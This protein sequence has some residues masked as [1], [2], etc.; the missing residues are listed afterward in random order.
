[1]SRRAPEQTPSPWTPRSWKWTLV[2][3]LGWLLVATLLA[4]RA[5]RGMSW[6]FE[7]FRLGALAASAREPLYEAAAAGPGGYLY[8]P[9]FALALQ[10]LTWFSSDTGLAIWTGASLIALFASAQLLEGAV[11]RWLGRPALPMFGLVALLVLAVPTASN[12]RW[13]NSNAFMM[14]LITGALAAHVARRPQWTGLLLSL[15]ATIKLT[16]FLFLGWLALRRDGRAL[17]AFGAGSVLW[18]A[19]IPAAALGP[20]YAMSETKA[21]LSAVVFPAAAGATLGDADSSLPR[22]LERLHASRASKRAETQ[23]AGLADGATSGTPASAEGQTLG[24]GSAELIR[25]L[26]ILLAALL[27]ALTAVAAAREPGLGVLSFGATAAAML[28]AAPAARSGH[29]MQ[30]YPLVGILLACAMTAGQPRAPLARGGLLAAIASMLVLFGCARLLGV[31]SKEF[32]PVTSL[33][34]VLWGTACLLAL[35]DPRP[36]SERLRGP[37][38]ANHAQTRQP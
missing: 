20:S 37:G 25:G 29:F 36:S 3:A 19:V 31:S 16:P 2:G 7:L 6:D 5:F 9:I 18:L 4:V 30:L 12:F 28:L 10:P 17:V 11:A 24:V 34:L 32:S 14:L 27:L 21:W 35:R 22:L 38:P 23:P 15:A 1:V 13:S 26:G 33:T 8:A